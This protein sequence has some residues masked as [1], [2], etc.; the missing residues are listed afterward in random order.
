MKNI[1]FFNKGK[2]LDNF[3]KKHF[4]FY[5]NKTKIKITRLF[6]KNKNERKHK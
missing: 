6:Y 5:E 1:R 3:Q 4:Q 2:I